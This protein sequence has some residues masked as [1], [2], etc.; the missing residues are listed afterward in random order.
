MLPICTW[1]GDA[2]QGYPSEEN[3]PFLPQQQS[4]MNNILVICGG[5][6]SLLPNYAGIMSDL[7]IVIQTAINL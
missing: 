1:Y 6:M 7:I 4:I 3:L 2:Y 5:F